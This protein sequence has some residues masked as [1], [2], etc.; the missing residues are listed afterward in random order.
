MVVTI[1]GIVYLFA[2]LLSLCVFSCKTIEKED[3]IPVVQEP[4]PSAFTGLTNQDVLNQWLE[5]KE[6]VKTEYKGPDKEE[7]QEEAPDE[8]KPPPESVAPS[9]TSKSKPSSGQESGSSS[10][11]ESEES[12][13]ES[14]KEPN[15]GKSRLKFK[16]CILANSLRAFVL[17]PI[18]C[19]VILLVFR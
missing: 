14:E 16:L 9:Q 3:N 6:F 10:S 8:S 13:E 12:E 11:E 2:M 17:F 4:E 19:L 5:G 1:F 7:P 18:F 15:I